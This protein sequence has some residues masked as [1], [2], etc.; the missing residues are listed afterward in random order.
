MNICRSFHNADRIIYIDAVL[1]ASFYSV[2]Q[3][4]RWVRI[5]VDQSKDTGSIRAY[6]K[7]PEICNS[8]QYNMLE[9][10]K[11]DVQ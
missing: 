7:C 11:N 6:G 1:V 10:L 8:K 3:L 9:L 4:I 5:S 2:F